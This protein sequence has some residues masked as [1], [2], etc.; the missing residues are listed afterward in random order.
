M[1]NTLF[2][3]LLAL[4]ILTMVAYGV[5]RYWLDDEKWFRRDT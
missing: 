4:G 1:H 3:I 2:V 5:A